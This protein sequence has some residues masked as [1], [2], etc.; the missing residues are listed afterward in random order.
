ML[1]FPVKHT[2]SK[3]RQFED[4]N[5][6]S[7]NIYRYDSKYKAAPLRVSEKQSRD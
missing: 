6:V 2:S 4:D 3:I 7:I 5:N 1:E